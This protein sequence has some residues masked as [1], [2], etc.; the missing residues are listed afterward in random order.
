[1]MRGNLASVCMGLMLAVLLLVPPL[2]AQDTLS[3]P[4]AEHSGLGLVIGGPS[5]VGLRIPLTARSALR[6]DLSVTRTTFNVGASESK[7][8]NV[9]LGLGLLIRLRESGSLTTYVTPRIALSRNTFDNGS[10]TDQ[11]FLDAALGVS[12]PIARRLSL[13]GEVGPRLTYTDQSTTSLVNR[14]TNVVI[15][16]SL[17]ATLSF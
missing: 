15:R 11:W 14:T 4:A 6:P 1:M 8:V 9:T 7:F 16:S 13:F 10:F 17:G 12:A 5:S 2:G 3:A